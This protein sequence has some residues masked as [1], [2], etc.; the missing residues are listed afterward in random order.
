MIKISLDIKKQILI[1]PPYKKQEEFFKAESRFVAYGGARGG[2]KSW[3]ARIKAALLAAEYDGIQILFLRR[4]L[5]ELKE[6][7]ILPF[8]KM[9][10]GCAV[11]KAQSRELIFPNTS[12]IVLGYLS[13]ESDV[14]Q[15]QGQ[16]YDVIF[17]EEATQFTSFQFYAL[18]EC[19]RSSGMCQKQ[20]FPRMYFTCNP[21]GVGHEWVKR[22][23]IDRIYKNSE[24]EEDYTFVRSGVYDNEFLLK[25]SPEY[26]RTLENLPEKRK[27]AM[28][29]GNWDIYEGQYFEEFD[30][31]VHVIRPFELSGDFSRYV[32]VDYG[33]DM[34]AALWVAVDR[35]GRA[36][37]YREVYEK[38][39]IVS[40]AAQLILKMSDG[41]KINMHFAPPD[42][43]SRRQESGKSVVDIFRQ[44]GLNF[45]K[46]DNSRVNGWYELKEWLSVKDGEPRLKIFENCR[47]L[48]RTLPALTFDT[49]NPNDVSSNPHELTH[50]PDAL[51]GFV[52]SDA[53]RVF[54]EEK[55]YKNDGY[56]AFL[57]YGV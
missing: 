32:S 40:K 57:N 21:G 53:A 14:L 13:N 18:T 39:L 31:S 17:M 6:N 49:K 10:K 36:Y 52:M 35:F 33:L 28:L 2:G 47:N 3:A 20:F 30:R 15:Y 26:I 41:E 50:A 51:R 8:L 16:S 38:N 37:V 5:H 1:T 45:Y 54:R 24:R 9:L 56:E 42:L 34:L 43:F 25:N 11:Y 48:I 27:Q 29:Y 22:L 55:T 23:F 44:F 12:R 46:T 19:N 4:H 7:H